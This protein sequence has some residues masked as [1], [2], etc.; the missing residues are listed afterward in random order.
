MRDQLP[1]GMLTPSGSLDVSRAQDPDALREQI[2]FSLASITLV[3]FSGLCSGLTLGL[4]SL[5]K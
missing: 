1:L 5:D 2:F 3:I 4:L